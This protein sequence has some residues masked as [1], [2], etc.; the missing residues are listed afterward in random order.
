M[1]HAIRIAILMFGLVGTFLVAAV[2]QVPTADGGPILMCPQNNPRCG[3]LP[4]A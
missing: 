4:P 2:P 3:S 1:K